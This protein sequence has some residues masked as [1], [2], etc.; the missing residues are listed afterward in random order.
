MARKVLR[1]IGYWRGDRDAMRWPDVRDFMGTGAGGADSA[2][3]AYL[4]SGTLFAAAAGRSPC[5]VCGVANGSGEVTD[6]ELFV[7]PEGL[8]HYVEAHGVV[9]PEEVVAAARR[10]VARA[11]DSSEFVRKMFDSGEIVIDDEW[12]GRFSGR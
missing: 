12:W 3:A 1:L 9:L 8:S 11:V 10:G 6:G 4:R 2:V 5:R 7:W